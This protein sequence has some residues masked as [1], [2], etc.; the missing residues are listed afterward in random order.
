MD[1]LASQQVTGVVEAIESAGVKLCC[2]PSYSPDLN[3]IKMLR[4]KIKTWLSRV[5]VQTDDALIK[6]IA[7]TLRSVDPTECAHYFAA[8]GNGKYL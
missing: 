1:N 5:T 3:P 4:S 6:A 2:L 7:D 8:C